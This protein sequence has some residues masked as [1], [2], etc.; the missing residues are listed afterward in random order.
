[1]IRRDVRSRWWKLRT[2]DWGFSAAL[3]LIILT[4]FAAGIL[5]TLAIL[6]ERGV[7]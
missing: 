7:L 1:M 5:T 6:H 4:S 2:F 3:L